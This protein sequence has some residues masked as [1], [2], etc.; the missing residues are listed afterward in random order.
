MQNFQC[1]VQLWDKLRRRIIEIR[2]EVTFNL[3]KGPFPFCNRDGRVSLPPRNSRE[4]SVFVAFV[5]VTFSDY[6]KESSQKT[7]LKVSSI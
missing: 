1:N 2:N 7:I 3:N 5:T 4:K 6:H